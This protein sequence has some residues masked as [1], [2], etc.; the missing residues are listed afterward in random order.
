MLTP[1]PS[2]LL[3]RLGRDVP[4]ARLQLQTLL[5]DVHSQR[6]VGAVLLAILG[7]KLEHIHKPGASNARFE[8]IYNGVRGTPM[9]T[10]LPG[11]T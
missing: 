11:F 4:T 3:S 5:I 8:S 9:R 7:R 2:F 6:M 10:F 1:L